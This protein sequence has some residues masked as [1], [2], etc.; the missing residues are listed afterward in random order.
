MAWSFIRVD[1]HRVGCERQ[2][3]VRGTSVPGGPSLFWTLGT[4]SDTKLP[5]QFKTKGP[6]SSFGP[7]FRCK[8]F[9]RGVHTL[10]QLL[11]ATEYPVSRRPALPH[12]R[13][14]LTT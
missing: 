6:D 12:P 14:L 8:G 9:A 13:I 1:C 10:P 7:I 2:A 4:G 5:V 11:L 3:K